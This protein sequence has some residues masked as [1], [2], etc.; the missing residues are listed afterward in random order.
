MAIVAIALAAAVA[1]MLAWRLGRP[2]LAW[3]VSCAV[4][5]ASVLYAEFMLPYQVGGASMWPVALVFGG[6]YGAAAGGMGTALGSALRN[7]LKRGT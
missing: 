7:Y 3:F 1:F 4:V 5:P 6:I 2:L